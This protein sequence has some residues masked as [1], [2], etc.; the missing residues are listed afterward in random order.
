MYDGGFQ[1]LVDESLQ[2]GTVGAIQVIS[3]GVVSC[4]QSGGFCEN[5]AVGGVVLQRRLQPDTD[6]CY[7]GVNAFE[8]GDAAGPGSFGRGEG[9]GKEAVLTGILIAFLAAGL[10]FVLCHVVT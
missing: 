5:T 6:E 10:S 3:V 8:V 2:V 7:F 4:E 9:S 1:N